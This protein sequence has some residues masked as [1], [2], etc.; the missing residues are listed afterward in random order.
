MSWFTDRRIAGAENGPRAEAF[1]CARGKTKK[2]MHDMTD[3]AL[4]A[5]AMA[6]TTTMIAI[7]LFLTALA[8]SQVWDSAVYIGG[9]QAVMS[10]DAHPS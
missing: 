8:A 2:G 4:S 1:C 9:L 5:L 10:P 7:T 6:W 3:T